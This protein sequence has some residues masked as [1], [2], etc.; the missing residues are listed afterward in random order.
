[1][2]RPPFLRRK[3]MFVDKSEAEYRDDGTKLVYVE[4]YA[5]SVPSTMPTAA[6]IPGYDSSFQIRPG[7]TLYIVGTGALYMANENGT[8][9]EQ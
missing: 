6:D 8:F 9:V 4:A 3:D 5:N 7:S 2:Q 1:M